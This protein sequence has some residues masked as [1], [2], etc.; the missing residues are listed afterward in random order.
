MNCTIG[1]SLITAKLGLVARW[2]V[3]W[4]DLGSGGFL[5]HVF[6]PARSQIFAL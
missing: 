6:P 4:K 3:K 2:V 1:E 5:K